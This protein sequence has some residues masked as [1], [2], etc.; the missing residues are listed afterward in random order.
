MRLTPPPHAGPG[1]LSLQP[2][3]VWFGAAPARVRTLLGSCVALTLWHPGLRVGGMCHYLLPSRGPHTTRT[4]DGRYGNEA[5]AL[6]LREIRRR[7]AVPAQFEAKLFG[8]GRMFASQ[9]GATLPG[10]DVQQRNVTQARALVAANGLALRAEHLGG[11]GHRL[12]VLDL[13][14]GDVWMRH[15]P[16]TLPHSDFAAL[17]P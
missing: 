8:G 12:I 13:A 16:L 14:T 5:F 11:V 7:G 10:M 15:T 17:A 4:L 1:D 3:E 2:G 9:P 6:L